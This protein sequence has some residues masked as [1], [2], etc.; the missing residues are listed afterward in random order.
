MLLRSISNSSLPQ[1]QINKNTLTGGEVIVN[2]NKHNDSIEFDNALKHVQETSQF[3]QHEHGGDWLNI[4]TEYIQE[5]SKSDTVDDI[6]SEFLQIQDGCQN[7]QNGCQVL[8]PPHQN[9]IVENPIEEFSNHVQYNDLDL[10]TL[11]DLDMAIMQPQFFPTP[12]HSENASSP[13]SDSQ[14]YKNS[15]YTYSP[16][17]STTLSPERASP[18]YNSDYEKFQEISHFDTTVDEKPRERKNSLSMTMKQY[19]DMQKE[20]SLNFSKKE[21]CQLSRKPCKQAFVD[22]LKSLKPEDRKEICLKVAKLDL[23]YAYGV[24][25]NILMNLAHGCEQEAVHYTVFCLVCERILNQEPAWFVEDFGL[26]LLKS[27]AL[28]CSHKPL[29]TR[30]L[31]E[32]VRTVMRQN[33]TLLQGREC[34]FHEV[35]A[36]GDTL[37]SACVRRGDSCADVLSELTRPQPGQIPLFRV[38]HVNADGA[39]ALHVACMEHSA[40]APRLHCAHVLLQH[41]AADIWQGD[42]KA[43]DTALHMAVAARGCDLRLIMVLFRHLDR[44]LWK[45]LAHVPNMCSTTPLE[46]ARSAMKCQTREYPPEVLEFLK[47]CR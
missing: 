17:R 25:Q 21:C 5:D 39:S 32:C 6:L 16:E 40:A 4:V 43:G 1:I 36:L 2:V 11:N 28:R 8:T 3:S 41:A 38:Q 45:R 12:P 7:T 23:K 35:D 20:I 37:V 42:A 33:G 30:Y 19:K 13:M 34:V 47:K 22:F 46:Y 15:E 24:L 31:V 29:L 18:V 26:N 9:E 14:S 44:K 27:S 10:T